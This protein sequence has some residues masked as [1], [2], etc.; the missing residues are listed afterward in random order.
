M[1]STPTVILF[2][3]NMK[4]PYLVICLS[5]NVKYNL[6]FIIAALFGED[7]V[8]GQDMF[9]FQS[10]HTKHDLQNKVLS[11]IS[12][13]PKPTDSPMRTP[14]KLHSATNSPLFKVAEATP[15]HVKEIMKKSK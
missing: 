14:K 4:L 2:D 6:Y 1:K 10:R 11:A 9:K 12:N 15:R 5:R 7:D 8:E 3:Y 13:S